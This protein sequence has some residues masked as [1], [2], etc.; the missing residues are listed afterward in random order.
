M[1]HEQFGQDY[2]RIRKFREIFFVALRQVQAA[3]PEAKLAGDG[4][5]MTLHRSSPPVRKRLVTVGECALWGGE[6]PAPLPS[7]DD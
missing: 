5:G 2:A 7:G 1:L 4:R 3:Y 6:P